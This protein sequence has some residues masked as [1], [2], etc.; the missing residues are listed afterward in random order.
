MDDV[1]TGLATINEWRGIYRHSDEGIVDHVIR[2]LGFKGAFTPEALALIA[3]QY[4]AM[5]RRIART[6]AHNAAL[7]YQENAHG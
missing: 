1:A 6:Q 3:D 4:R 2:K 7:R 5:E